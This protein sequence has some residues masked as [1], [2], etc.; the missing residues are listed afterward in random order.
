MA[1]I[2]VFFLVNDSIF[3]FFFT[4]ENSWLNKPE[5]MNLQQTKASDYFLIN[6]IL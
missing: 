4:F 3:F 5:K 6:L 2:S 1:T